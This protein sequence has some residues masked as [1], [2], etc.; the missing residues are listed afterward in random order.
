MKKSQF[1]E[2]TTH[3]N[4]SSQQT[5]SNSKSE[6]LNY[7]SVSLEKGRTNQMLVQSFN[8]YNQQTNLDYPTHNQASH[9]NKI[10]QA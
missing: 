2:T 9:Q 10:H 3:F 8:N 1:G 4:P 5:G 6:G 7:K